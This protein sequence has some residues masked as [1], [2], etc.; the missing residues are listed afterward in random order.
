MSVETN[1]V[2]TF[3]KNDHG[4]TLK[5]EEGWLD[6][7]AVVLNV[8][9]KFVYIA[10]L[11]IRSLMF[12]YILAFAD[13]PMVSNMT[14]G[15]KGNTTVLECEADANPAALIKFKG[16]KNIECETNFEKSHL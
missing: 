3:T 14:V 9:C 10:R 15:V 16:G 4:K 13:K 7:D 2:Y 12:M 5:C 1:L 8:T 11:L 6:N